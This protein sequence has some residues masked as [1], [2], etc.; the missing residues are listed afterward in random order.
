MMM[1]LKGK[2]LPNKWIVL[3]LLLGIAVFN[4]ADRFLL[5]GLVEPIKAEFGLS[6]GFMGLLMGPAFAVFYSTLAI[7]IAIMADRHS[8]IRIIIAGCVIWSIFTILCGFADGPTSLAFYR[9]GVGVGEAAFQAPAFSLVAAYFPA[10]QRGKAFAVIALS[11]YFGQMLGYSAGP[12]IAEVESWRFA[13][14]LFGAVG[15]A[16]IAVAWLVIRE[17]A[18]TEPLT[19]RLP[20]IPLAKRLLKLASYR[21]MMFGMGL[22]VLSGIAFGYWGPALFSRNYNMTITEA[23]SAFGSAFVLPGMIGAILF[24][25]VSDKL[26]KAGYGRMLLLAAISLTGATLAVLGAVWAGS[27]N[28]ALL[29][30]IPAG[31]L[32]GGWAVGIQAGLQYILPDRMRATGTAVALLTVN[33]LGYVVGP[34]LTG[35]LSNFFG[36]G[37][38]GLQMSLSV[39]VPMGLIGAFLLW[40]GSLKLDEDRKTLHAGEVQN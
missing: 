3:S 4:H 36:E 12:A 29:W 8:R 6:D 20:F 38:T 27:L 13:F 10:E 1:D 14:I 17:P 5:A 9:V 15:L 31:I 18:R 34:W 22:G 28:N 19:V 24:G 11:V 40:R 30:A 7:P 35:G 2:P 25:I 21:S 23:G 33:L 32:G 16:I 26:I 37:A 39:V